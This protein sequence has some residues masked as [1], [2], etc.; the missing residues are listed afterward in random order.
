M[1]SH[2]L[3]TL[4]AL[5]LSLLLA[6]AAR[7]QTGPAADA[8]PFTRERVEAVLTRELA[9][10][11]HVADELQIELLR[12]WTPPARLASVWTINVLEFPLVPVSSMLLR[13]RVLADAV[14]V[15][16]VVIALRASL[17]SEV[18]VARQP[19]SIGISFDRALLEVR[20]V[21]LL[22]EHDVLPATAGDRSYM[23]ARAV[24]AGHLLTWRDILR[25]PLVR[26]GELV[27]V[28]ALDGM[29]LVTLKALAMENG[30]RGET[31]TLRNP[32]SRKNF[33]AVVVDENRVQVRF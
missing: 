20:R 12:P 18:W 15:A 19:L 2:L 25:R 22:R 29:L 7:A 8:A 1:H 10:H 27:D 30:G 24:P 26:K 3:T 9:A 11:F 28:V 17:W 16:D 32:E 21:D 5:A 4:R 33:S 23:V 13:C 14:P 31:V 6:P